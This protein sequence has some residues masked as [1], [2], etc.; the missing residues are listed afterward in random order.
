LSFTGRGEVIL[1]APGRDALIR[2]L[3]AALATGNHPLMPGTD[4][5][6]ALCAMLPRRLRDA[7][8]VRGRQQDWQQAD[9]DAV[10]FE[11][12]PAEADRIRVR[13][14]ARN[15]AIVPLIVVGAGHYPLQRLL[16]EHAV[17][18]NTAAAGGNATLMRLA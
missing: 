15:G 11:G 3:A 14:A 18:I 8:E 13:L 17:S 12:D 9:F 1:V 6:R 2:Q 7:I 10:M 16:A 4:V 5:T